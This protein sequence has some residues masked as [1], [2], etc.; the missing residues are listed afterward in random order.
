MCQLMRGPLP[1]MA[2][3]PLP[4]ILKLVYAGKGQTIDISFHLFF[5]F[6]KIRGLKTSCSSN[7]VAPESN[8]PAGRPGGSLAGGTFTLPLRNS[9]SPISNVPT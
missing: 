7:V 3:S 2:Y 9:S 8:Q 6:F 1:L 4:P 5:L